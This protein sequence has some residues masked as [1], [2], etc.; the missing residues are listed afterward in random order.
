MMQRI[1]LLLGALCALSLLTVLA[2]CGG[3]SSP[4][5][6]VT[7]LKSSA[8]NSISLVGS[9]DALPA[10]VTPALITLTPKVEAVVQMAP[11]GATFVA[12][13]DCA[14]SGTVFL[15]P[16][17]LVFKLPSAQTVGDK[18]PV[19]LLT[20][21]GWTA[22]GDLAT[23][24]AS[25][26]TATVAIMHFS[27]YGLFVTQQTTLPGDKYFRF[28]QG[29]FA[30][31]LPSEIMYN[32]TDRTLY[33]PHA[34]VLVVSQAYG[35]IFRA[36]FGIYAD[37]NGSTPPVFHATSGLVYV[38]RSAPPMSSGAPLYFKLQIISATL[39]SGS[40]YGAVTFKFEQILPI[41]II[42]VVGEWAFSGGAH[43]SVFPGGIMMDLVP[44]SGSSVISVNGNYTNSSTL[45]GTWVSTA[46]PLSNGTITVAMSL[47]GA[48][49]NATITG[50]NGLSPLTLTNGIKQ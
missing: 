37:S 13:V 24:D 26:L 11:I 18:L 43:L 38:F 48:N 44:T 15:K 6:P 33:L 23:V 27:I 34:A 50:T 46:N 5:S 7:T 9:T 1:T 16:V 19:Y 39:H 40:V 2:G 20:G 47:T 42:N 35:S 45:S 41:N 29:V 17:N 31:G 10:G 25:G 30:G 8:D 36:P 14:P 28:D 49:L 12:A 3:G 4:A 22:D 32:D 21:S